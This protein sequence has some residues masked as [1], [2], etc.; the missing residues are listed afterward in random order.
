MIGGFGSGFADIDGNI[1]VSIV[2]DP[3]DEPNDAFRDLSAT[4][5]HLTLISVSGRVL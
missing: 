2:P 5:G 3:L 4:I 1:L